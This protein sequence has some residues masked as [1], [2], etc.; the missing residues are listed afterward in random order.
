M[1]TWYIINNI[2]NQ[3]G[4]KNSLFRRWDWNII[5][6]VRTIQICTSYYKFQ[7]DQKSSGDPLKKNNR[8][9]YIVILCCQDFLKQCF[10]FFTKCKKEG[11]PNFTTYILKFLNDKK[12]TIAR[13]M[14]ICI[15]G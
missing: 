14:M 7:M 15:I 8:G 2:R 11:K 9:A 5:M 3:W 1:G 13:Q 6:H 12:N 4:K 10:F